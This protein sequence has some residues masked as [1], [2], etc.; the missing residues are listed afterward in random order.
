MAAA[1]ANAYIFSSMEKF[2]DGNGAELN[3]FLSKFDRCCVIGNKVDGDTPVKGQLLMLFVEGRARA[4]LEEYEQTQGGNQQTYDALAAKL[5]EHFDNAET[6]ENSMSMFDVSCQKVNESEEEFMLRLLMLYKTANP[7][8]A[9][10]VT[11][12]AVKRKFLAGILVALKKNVYVSCRNPLEPNVT[13]G[14]LLSHCRK[15]RNLMMNS[16]ESDSYATDKVLVN[17]EGGTNN[18]HPSRDTDLVSAINNLSLRF[19]EHVSNTEKRFEE[20]G[21]VMAVIGG[22]SGGFRQRGVGRG[23]GATNFSGRGRGNQNNYR[24]YANNNNQN[25]ASSRGANNNTNRRN[26]GGNSTGSSARLCYNCGGANHLARNC[27]ASPG[28]C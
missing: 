18:K 1:S 22:S 3:S 13:R 23:R 14:E 25:R 16:V 15:A 8:R 28:N 9:E 26:D 6:R 27:T 17:A 7:N 24:R 2:S 19:Q 10:A 21:G 5:R 20:M 4:A 12:L 11:L